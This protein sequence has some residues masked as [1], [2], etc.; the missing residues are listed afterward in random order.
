M[1]FFTNM[2]P[3]KNHFYAIIRPYRNDFIIAPKVKEEEV[4]ARHFTYLKSLLENGKLFLAGPTL[5]DSDPFGVIIF[6][7]E[8]EEEAKELLM[9]DPSIK[10]GIQ[11][12][13]DFRPIRLSLIK[14]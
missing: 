6:E 1:F 11:N 4:M 13:A 3:E 7:T 2:T 5:I 8:T 12:V 9:D 14:K 10:I